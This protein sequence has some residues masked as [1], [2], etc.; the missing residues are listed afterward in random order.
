MRKRDEGL[1]MNDFLIR[2]SIQYCNGILNAFLCCLIY[3]IVF[4]YGMKLYATFSLRACDITQ[5]RGDGCKG[6]A[7][8]IT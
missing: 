7:L 2:F 6:P 4:H 3:Q 8:I 1:G 5:L